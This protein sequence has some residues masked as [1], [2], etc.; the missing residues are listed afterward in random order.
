M[1]ATAIPRI[2][3][4]YDD[5]MDVADQ[6]RYESRGVSVP[7]AVLHHGKGRRLAHQSK[8]Q[9]LADSSDYQKATVH[10][11]HRSPHYTTLL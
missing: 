5:A 2:K 4:E 11:L 1:F 8:L 10:D 9:L 7:C 3:R 6:L